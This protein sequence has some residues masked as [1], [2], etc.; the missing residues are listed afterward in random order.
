MAAPVPA[1]PPLSPYPQMGVNGFGGPPP[2]KE[3][4]GRAERVEPVA[5]TPFA[6]V[7]L[8]VPSVVSG[9]AIGSLITGIVAL[10]V[11]FAVVCFGLL[12]AESGWG[13]LVAGAFALLSVI[14]GAGSLVQGFGAL[15]QIR[16]PAEASSIRFSGRGLA[17]AGLSCGGGGAAVAL[18]ALLIVVILGLS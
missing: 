16:R 5:E 12:G 14:A 2:P 9:L 4:W 3:G 6:V 8:E 11:S 1:G 10:L 18:L 13:A 15:R 17:I 7:H